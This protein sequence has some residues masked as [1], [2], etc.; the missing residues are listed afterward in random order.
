MHHKIVFFV[1]SKRQP[2]A[3]VWYGDFSVQLNVGQRVPFDI[4]SFLFLV[5]SYI[6]D[7]NQFRLTPYD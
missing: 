5:D 7:L 4:I 3:I 1:T 6:F 2:R